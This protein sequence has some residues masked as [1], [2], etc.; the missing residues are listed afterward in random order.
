MPLEINEIDIR[1]HLG[2]QTEDVKQNKTQD[3]SGGC[4]D[5][6]HEAIVADC[7]RRVLL[8]L[9]STQER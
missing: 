9:M 6:D 3:D 7:T 1:M 5:Q 4:G 2:D 8:R